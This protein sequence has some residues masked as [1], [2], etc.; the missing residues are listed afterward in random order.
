MLEREKLEV[1]D[2]RDWCMFVAPIYLVIELIE[3]Y[4]VV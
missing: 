1:R 3:G 4:E 2:S